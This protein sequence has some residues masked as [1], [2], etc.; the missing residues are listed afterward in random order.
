ML[1]GVVKEIKNNENRVALTP[2]GVHSLI[3]NGHEVVIER[4]AGLGSGFENGEY[5]KQGAKL[6]NKKSDIYNM[7]DIICK[8]KEP[9]DIEYDM[10]KEKGTIFTYLHLAPNEKLTKLLLEKKVSAIAYETVQ[11]EDDSLPLLIPMSEVAGRMSVQV[12]AY[13]LQKNNNGRGMLLSG[14]PGVL[15]ANVVIIGGGTAGLNAARIAFGMGANVTV[16]DINKKKMIFI[17][18]LYNGQIKT[19]VSNTYNIKE[20]VKTADLLIGAVL[21][22]GKTAP[23]LVTEEMVKTMKKGSVIVDIAIDQGGC[24]ETIDRITTHDNPYYIK[25][26]VIHYSVANIPG[27]VPRTSTFA[28]E[29]VTLPY[30]IKLANRGINAALVDDE[31]LMKGLNTYNGYVT[32]LAVAESLN[33]EYRD[34]YELVSRW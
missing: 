5:E 25:H 18:E 31:A 19:L 28:L 3:V 4:D 27:A 23:N 7:A 13:F 2:A 1:I 20:A 6:L 33:M 34:P 15:P 22:P 10:I 9:I 32:N 11:L 12:G 16:L 17:D 29:S 8:V 14:V 30:L 26:D 24:I 21:I